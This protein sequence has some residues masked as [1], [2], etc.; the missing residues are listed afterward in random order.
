M[1]TE[2]PIENP[3]E[4][5]HI[6]QQAFALTSKTGSSSL[7]PSREGYKEVPIASLAH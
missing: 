3:I 6:I 4:K 7:R 5:A 2:N 1:R